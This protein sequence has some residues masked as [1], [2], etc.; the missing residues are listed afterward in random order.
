MSTHDLGAIKQNMSA[1]RSPP[2]S[3]G[4]DRFDTRRIARQSKMTV[5]AFPGTRYTTTTQSNMPFSFRML[6]RAAKL[7]ARRTAIRRQG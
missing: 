7:S 2:H 4:N 5:N 1:S 3:T 6:N